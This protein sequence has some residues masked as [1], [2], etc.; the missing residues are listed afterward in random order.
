MDTL[1]KLSTAQSPQLRTAARRANG[2]V[3]PP[4]KLR[5]CARVKVLPLLL[6]RGWI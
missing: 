1:A 2:R 4:E 6:Q 5:C 3:I